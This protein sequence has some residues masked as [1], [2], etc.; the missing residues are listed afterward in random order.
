M[1]LSNQVVLCG[2]RSGE[3]ESSKRGGKERENYKKKCIVIFVYSSEE[4]RLCVSSLNYDAC[5]DVMGTIVSE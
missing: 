4:V 3:L 5:Y 1:H 2:F